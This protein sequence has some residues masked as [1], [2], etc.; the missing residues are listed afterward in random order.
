MDVVRH[1]AKPITRIGTRAGLTKKADEIVVVVGAMVDTA[2]FIAAVED[3]VTVTDDGGTGGSRHL[4][5][6]RWP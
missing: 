5:I 4:V 3:V 2:A 1:Q 6:V